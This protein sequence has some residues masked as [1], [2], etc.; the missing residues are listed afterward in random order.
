[1][2]CLT[3]AYLSNWWVTHVVPSNVVNP[4]YYVAFHATDAYCKAHCGQSTWA[5]I[6][7]PYALANNINGTIWGGAYFQCQKCSNVLE[8]APGDPVEARS[9]RHVDGRQIKTAGKPAVF[10]C[11]SV[12]VCKKSGCL[13]IF[14]CRHPP[15]AV[16]V[17]QKTGPDRRGLWC[18]MPGREARI[19][20]QNLYSTNRV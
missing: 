5:V 11:A 6:T 13:R 17:A 2:Q 12:S 10:S 4:D 14:S 18:C 15:V 3:P 20:Y 8:P 9:S 7:G 19:G 16:S 1:V